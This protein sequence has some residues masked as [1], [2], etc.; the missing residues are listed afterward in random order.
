MVSKIIRDRSLIIETGLTEFISLVLEAT[1]GEPV[2]PIIVI[3]RV[4]SRGIEVQI[5]TVHSR[6]RRRPIVAVRPLIVHRT[7]RVI[8]VAWSKGSHL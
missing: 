6:R 8:A 1:H 3:R 4:N 2:R 5:V 7:V